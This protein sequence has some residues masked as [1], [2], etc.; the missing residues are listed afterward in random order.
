VDMLRLSF[1]E[2]VVFTG[3]RS[4]IHLHIATRQY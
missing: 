2:R 4:R 3:A 1:P